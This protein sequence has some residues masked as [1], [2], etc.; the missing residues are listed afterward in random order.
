MAT[1]LTL[2][3]CAHCGKTGTCTRGENGGSCA[4]CAR[5]GLF[6]TYSPAHGLV[7][8]ICRGTGLLEP[9][10]QRLAYGTGPAIALLVMV[11]TVVTI[12]YGHEKHFTEV[13]AFLGTLTG[14]ITGY[15]FSRKSG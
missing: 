12:I 1:D 10:S 7:C 5:R 14:S 3:D 6:G 13:L 9:V 11:I 15:Y 2:T 8:S 4:V